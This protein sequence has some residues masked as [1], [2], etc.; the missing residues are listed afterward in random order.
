MSEKINSVLKQLKLTKVRE[1]LNEIIS[2]AEKE[3]LS[4]EEFLLE[5]LQRESDSREEKRVQRFLKMSNLDL[6]K[7]IESFDFKRLSPRL[8]SQVKTL[9]TGHFL[10]KKENILAFGNPGGGKTHILTAIAI[11]LCKKGYRTYFSSCE[12]L[13]EDLLVQK[14]KLSLGDYFKKLDKFENIFIDDIGYVQKSREE[15]EVLFSLLAH[16]YERK[17]IMITSNLVFSKWE[18]IFKDKL[19]TAAA[20]DRMVHHCVILEMDLPSYRITNSN[21]DPHY[22]KD[23]TL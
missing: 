1:D 19:T 10:K 21:K 4:Y 5:L 8:R 9:S 11:E 18:L 15:M 3:S 14:S 6:R 12:K 23:S 22:E 16:R 17:S 13:V 7:T 20:I 2:I